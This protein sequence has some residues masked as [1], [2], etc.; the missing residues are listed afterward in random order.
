MA[1]HYINLRS[2]A[3]ASDLRLDVYGKLNAAAQNIRFL[4]V[5]QKRHLPVARA[6]RHDKRGDFEFAVG[7]HKAA[8]V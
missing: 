3:V 2:V 8:G 1:Y 7:G 6:G 5:A 4:K